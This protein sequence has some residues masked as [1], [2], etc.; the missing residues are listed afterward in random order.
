[1]NDICKYL[2]VINQNQQ[3]IYDKLKEIECKQDICVEFIN[4]VKPVINTNT[5]NIAQIHADTD[6]IRKNLN[7]GGGKNAQHVK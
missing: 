2:E 3:F 7:K 1:M 4:N 6:Y 5:M